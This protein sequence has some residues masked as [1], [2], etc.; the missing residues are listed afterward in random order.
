M[1]ESRGLEGGISTEKGSS[2]NHESIDHDHNNLDTNKMLVAFL[3]TS[4]EHY[5]TLFYYNIIVVLR[6]TMTKALVLY[7]AHWPT[8]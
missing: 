3:M 6:G 4:L 8:R 1:W 7:P 2:C 5:M